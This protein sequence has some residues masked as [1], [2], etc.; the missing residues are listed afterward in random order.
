M[1]ET[2]DRS[3][4]TAYGGDMARGARGDDGAV[5]ASGSAGMGAD[6]FP[7]GAVGPVT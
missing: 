2:E 5:E 3:P 1:S 7:R 6:D 4:D